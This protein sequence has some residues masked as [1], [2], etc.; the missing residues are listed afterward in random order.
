MARAYDSRCYLPGGAECQPGPQ[1]AH[2][3]WIGVSDEHRQLW[4]RTLDLAGLSALP[5]AQAEDQFDLDVFTAD[6]PVDVAGTL[7]PTYTPVAFFD[8]SRAQRR[9]TSA[10]EFAQLPDF[11]YALWDWATGLETCPLDPALPQ[12]AAAGPCHDFSTHMGAV[13]S[14]HF[15]PQAQAFFAYYHALAIGRAG[16]CRTMKEKL[17][18]ES[19]RFGPFLDACA[20]EAFVLEAIGHHFLQDAWSS[21]HMWE[22]WGSPDLIDFT[23]YPHALLVGMTAGLIHGARAV[24]Q[25]KAGFVG[26]DVNDALC[27][28]GPAVTFADPAATSVPALGD[29]YLG[30]L[31]ANDGAAFPEQYQQLFSCAAAAVRQV[32]AALGESAGGLDPSLV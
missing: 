3:R 1:S 16:A 12:P 19:N 22:R 4:L 13:N 27:A 18:A 2:N 7:M 24:L 9:T 29:L 14:N 26:F 17:G 31:L 23:D 8:A 10:P 11:G 6:D 15:L 5:A 21:G 28:P 32:A 25:D 20:Q 30:S